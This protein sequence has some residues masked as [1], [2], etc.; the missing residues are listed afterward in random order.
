M[1]AFLGHSVNVIILTNSRSTVSL[2]KAKSTLR[3]FSAFKGNVL[4]LKRK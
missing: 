3:Q 4:D 2:L 1:G